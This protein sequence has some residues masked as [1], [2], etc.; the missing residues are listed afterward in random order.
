MLMDQLDKDV[1]QLKEDG[2]EMAKA[3]ATYRIELAKKMR[4]LRRDGVAWSAMSDLCR[5]DPDIAD[6]KEERDKREVIYKASQEALNTHKLAIRVLQDTVNKAWSAQGGR[7][8][9]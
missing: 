1:D 4:E 9:Y 2:I 7:Y 8:E 6:L 5:G 3:E